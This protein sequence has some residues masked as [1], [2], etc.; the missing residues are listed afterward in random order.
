MLIMNCELTVKDHGDVR[1]YLCNEVS[2]AR[3]VL[4]G[5]HILSIDVI[6]PWNYPV[7]RKL[8]VDNVSLMYWRGSVMGFDAEFVGYDDGIRRELMSIRLFLSKD[9][10]DDEVKEL[11]LRIIKDFGNDKI[12][13]NNN[14]RGQ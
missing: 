10:G 12:H 11:I 3:L 13:L 2:V 7:S 6:G 5:E 9:L 8:S 14:V 1:E 4:H